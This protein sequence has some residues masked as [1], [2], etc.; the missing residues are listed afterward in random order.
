MGSA[1]LDVFATIIE[2]IAILV[3]LKKALS[4]V[5]ELGWLRS[6][7]TSGILTVSL[8]YILY[9][10]RFVLFLTTLWFT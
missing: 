3:Y 10:Y 9:G 4:T 6:W 7:I 2:A 8:L 5:Y 1:Y